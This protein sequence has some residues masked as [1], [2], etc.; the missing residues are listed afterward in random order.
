MRIKVAVT[1]TAFWQDR[2]YYAAN[3]NRSKYFGT[4]ATLEI[5]ERAF[6]YDDDGKIIVDAEYRPILPKWA[7]PLGE[8]PKLDPSKV[9][10]RVIDVTEKSREEK[11]R[12]SQAVI[13]DPEPKEEELVLPPKRGPGRPRKNDEN[14]LA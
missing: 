8:V 4:A 10:C 9:P 1:K 6:H 5:D 11:R 3:D 14:V 13:A 12:A 2:L 7:K